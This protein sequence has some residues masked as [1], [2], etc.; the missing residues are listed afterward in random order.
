MSRDYPGI[1]A[2]PGDSVQA[3]ITVEGDVRWDQLILWI[4]ERDSA[5]GW[6]PTAMRIP[7]DCA[8]HLAELILRLDAWRHDRLEREAIVADGRGSDP[9]ALAEDRLRCLR[10][11]LVRDGAIDEEPPVPDPPPPAGGGM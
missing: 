9:E 10:E 2:Q 4:G 1:P 3:M 11:S 7:A 6:E 5:D 8:V